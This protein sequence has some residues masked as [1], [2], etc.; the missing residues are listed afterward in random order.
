[1][2]GDLGECLG[3]TLLVLGACLFVRLLIATSY[4]TYLLYSASSMLVIARFLDFAE[5]IPQFNALPFIGR[6]SSAHDLLQSG[7]ESA[8]YI[9]VLCTLLAL[10]F[11][12]S[13]LKESAE[14]AHV[15]WRLL[16][17]KSLH[18]ARVA[19]MSVDAV[20]GAGRSA[21][22]QTLN[23][24]A[25]ALFGYDEQEAVG[26]PLHSLFRC[27]LQTDDCSIVERVLNGQNAQ[28]IDLVG[29][30]KDRSEVA[31]A[32]SFS[33][34]IG[35]GGE[36]VGVSAFIRDIA[37][38]K[39]AER[40]LI[41]SRKLLAGALHSANVGMF[42]VTDKQGMFEYNAR[43]EEITG[44]PIDE[45]QAQGIDET[46][47]QCVDISER[48]VQKIRNQVLHEG[49]ALDFRNMKIK[50][51]DGTERTCNLSLVP[52]FDEDDQ[53]VAVA[54]VAVDITERESLQSKL[55][56]SQKLE[57][58]GR[59]AGGVAHDFNNILGGI[60]GY[61]TL[62]ADTVEP[63]TNVHNYAKAVENAALRAAELTR[64]LLTF[65]R[66]GKFRQEPVDLNDA[67][68]ETLKL[69]DS[70]LTPS[71]SVQFE[72]GQDLKLIDAD[73]SQ[74][75]QVLMNLCLNSRDALHGRPNSRIVV[76]TRNVRVDAAL[77]EQL[78][79]NRTGDYVCLAVEDNGCGIESGLTRKI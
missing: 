55:L 37:N 63:G 48:L 1:M 20:I 60:L 75:E 66:S 8:G 70:T 62:M 42:I 16:H 73:R 38:R 27:K 57:S 30:T 68:R 46:L 56:E 47:N 69:L 29:L 26:L 18:L 34:V 77:L 23:A 17:E 31:V 28:D 67:V 14:R 24:G 59:L 19:D 52:V 10:M 25:C 65:A 61:A 58:V 12:L 6:Y 13:K 43:M 22:I 4:V 51:K 39:R 72:P 11:E 53:P 3:T 40:E 21:R 49:R 2:L 45:V 74:M 64:Q 78:N 32:A 50:R 5:E 9:L 7:F 44:F 79:L 76:S 15:E 33:P 36:I 35:Q 41:N 71:V 54:G